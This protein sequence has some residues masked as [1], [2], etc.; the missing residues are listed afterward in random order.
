MYRLKPLVGN[1][2]PRFAESRDQ[3]LD[4][5]RVPSLPEFL[6]RNHGEVRSYG[7]QLL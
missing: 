7:E 3:V 1:L 6:A 5:L 2:Q 4:E